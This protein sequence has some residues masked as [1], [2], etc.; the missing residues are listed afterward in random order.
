MNMSAQRNLVV[1]PL[2]EVDHGNINRMCHALAKGLRQCG[3]E[4]AII[5]YREPGEAP[6]RRLERLLSSGRVLAIMTLN[7]VGFPRAAHDLIA[8]QKVQ[9]FVYGTDH[10]C[11]LFP[12]ME[13]APTGT[14]LSFPSASNVKCCHG[15]GL[16]S[17]S[18]MH[19][20]HGAEPAPPRAWADRGIPFLLVGNLRQSSVQLRAAWVTRGSEI[21]ILEAM[22]DMLGDPGALPLEELCQRAIAATGNSDGPL[23]APRA[24]AKMLR[25]FDPYARAVVREGMLKALS[26]LPLT[27]VGDWSGLEANISDVARFT[28]PL[29]S[30][31]VQNMAE[32]AQCIVDTTPAYYSSHE[33]IFEGLAGGSLVAMVGQTDFDDL[34]ACGALIQA[35]Q[36]DQ[37]ADQIAHF[38]DDGEDPAQRA[39]AGRAAVLHDHTWTSRARCIKD[40][41]CGDTV[42]SH[43]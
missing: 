18:F 17:F 27:V 43:S 13:A 30:K 21:P 28:G 19:V 6:V 33:R 38:L 5:D 31:T 25:Y 16:G 26:G 7:A 1:L 23:A 37:L 42:P 12:L 3:L 36:H 41:L 32:R 14:T 40:A 35:N 39:D 15:W 8:H 22:A 9:L 29:D 11:H 2:A 10:P 4:P 34:N 20:P 24:I